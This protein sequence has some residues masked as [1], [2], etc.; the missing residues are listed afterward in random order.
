MASTFSLQSE[1]SLKGKQE[2]SGW[3]VDEESCNDWNEDWSS[4]A[5]T[6]AKNELED[7]DKAARKIQ[8]A[9]RAQQ[10]KNEIEQ[11]RLAK[12]SGPMKLGARKV[13]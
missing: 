4:S 9:Q 12:Q 13:T 7:D 2:I 1:S 6:Q 10:R 11:K 3:D 8:A 5:R